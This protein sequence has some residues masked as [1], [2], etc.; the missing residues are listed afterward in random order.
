[1]GNDP[2]AECDFDMSN[3]ITMGQ[4]RK[5]KKRMKKLQKKIPDQPDKIF[6]EMQKYKESIYV[7]HQK[8]IFNP[9]K[10]MQKRREKRK[11]KMEQNAKK[12][13]AEIRQK[14]LDRFE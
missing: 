6:K 7:G 10:E 2:Q 12:R 11:N 5:L 4:S 3:Q 14:D 13:K 1:M 9:V 8:K